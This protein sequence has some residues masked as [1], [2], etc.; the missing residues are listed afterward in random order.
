MSLIRCRLNWLDLGRSAFGGWLLQHEILTF[1]AGQDDL[2]MVHT[3]V[4][5]GVLF[6]AVLVQTVWIDRPLRIIGPTFFITGLTIAVSGPLIGGFALI[7][8]LACALMF[9]RLSL[10]F[11]FVP[12]A[13]V[14][15]GFMFHKMSPL[16]LFNAAMFSIP[17]LLAFAFGVRV[18]Y[19]RRPVESQRHRK[20]SGR[21][22]AVQQD[23]A[24][25][26]GV[27][28]LA[29]NSGRNKLANRQEAG[30]TANLD[31]PRVIN[32]QDLTQVTGR[33]RSA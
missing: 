8:G 15:F 29:G 14:A 28:I 21:I 16:L 12:A 20:G 19:V 4:Q 32:L 27:S 9:R 10:S 26:E 6:I 22:G 13:L 17:T 31:S 7:L 5:V 18:S 30:S 33:E 25:G 1:R 2:A 3:F 24:E 23:E 11:I